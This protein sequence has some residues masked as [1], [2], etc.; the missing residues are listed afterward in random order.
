MDELSLLVWLS[1]GSKNKLIKL[2]TK[3]ADCEGFSYSDSVLIKYMENAICDFNR[4]Y[5]IKNLMFNYFDA[6]HRLQNYADLF[7]KKCTYSEIDALGS[8]I[9]LIP[10]KVFD[11]E[12]TKKLNELRKLYCEVKE[13]DI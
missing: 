8:V 7:P 13:N 10:K 11:E 3:Y 2:L 12:D 9:F 5:H 4:N 1:R 6:K